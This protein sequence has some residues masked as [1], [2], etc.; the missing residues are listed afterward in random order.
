MPFQPFFD[1]SDTHPALA[2]SPVIRGLT[3]TFAYLE[4]NGPIGL[5]PSGNL[6]RVFV[7][8]AAEAFDW[9]GHRP[10]DLYAVNKVLNEWDFFPLAELHDIMLALRI[11]RHFKGTF[12][13]TP[14][15]RTFVGHPGRLFE[16]VAPFYLFRV[17]HTH[18]TRF[19]KALLIG[20]WD[21]FLNVINV[22]AAGG[23]T[24]EQLRAALYGPPAPGP[25]YDPFPGKLYVE[26]LRPLCW[27]GLLQVVGEE[28]LTGRD[29][30]YV[31][32]PLWY[33]ALQL[34]TDRS[35]KT[36]VTH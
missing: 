12:R 26:V 24:A 25:H 15:G 9:P 31:K 22:L 7:T 32:T 20:N 11:G 17:D 3:K 1:L 34:D 4:E 28:R 6:K 13:L 10:D 36:I 14:F 27:L 35:L 16:L 30:V 18:H 29:N 2:H 19:D 21:I 33:A 5:T 8:W 23:V